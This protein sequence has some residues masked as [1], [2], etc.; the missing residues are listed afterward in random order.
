MK[1]KNQDLKKGENK[2]KKAKSKTTTRTTTKKEPSSNDN[3]NDGIGHIH[4]I[5]AFISFVVGIVTPK[6]YSYTIRTRTYYNKMIISSS[7]LH[8]L[9]KTTSNQEV[10]FI[11]CNSDNLSQFLHDEPMKGLHILC[12]P[13]EDDQ[14]KITIYKHASQKQQQQQQ[15]SPILSSSIDS[16]DGLKSF[17]NENVGIEMYN[18][19]TSTKQPWAIFSTNGKQLVHEVSNNNEYNKDQV[20]NVLKEHGMVLLFEGGSW[21]WPGVKIG[22][23]RTIEIDDGNTSTK[24][25]ITIETLSLYPLVLSV[26]GFIHDH[27]CTHVQDMA[28]PSIQYSQVTLMD[29]DQGRPASDFRTSQSTFL[30]A[31]D[32]DDILLGLDFRT[33][34]L[35]R[36]PREHQEHTQVLRYGKT[37]KYSAHLDWFDKSLYLQDQNTLDLI[38]NGKKNRLVTVFWYLSGKF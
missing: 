29:K 13:Q 9:D 21:L 10:I 37:E 35:T 15:Q 36:V 34:S 11:E 3:Y 12:F 22:F 38:D 1:N 31:D 24:R 18:R 30:S 25:N 33:A 4:Y 27:E 23:Q 20:I 8:V 26:E 6:L 5:L 14:N 2:N 32:D 16:F 19:D 28:E 7:L 17:L